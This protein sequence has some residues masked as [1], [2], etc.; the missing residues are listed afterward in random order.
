MV[1]PDTL[2]RPESLERTGLLDGEVTPDGLGATGMT[3]RGEM[4][5]MG[6]VV[7]PAGG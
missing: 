4:M 1:I 7:T 6:L 2:V 5:F 3:E